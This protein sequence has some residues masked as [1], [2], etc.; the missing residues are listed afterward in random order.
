MKKIAFDL[1]GTLIT[2]SGLNEDFKIPLLG[3]IFKI[4][5]LRKGVKDLFEYLKAK[6]YQICIYTSSYR[7]AFYIKF[8]FMLYLIKLDSIINQYIHEKYVKV[9]SSKFPPEFGIDILVDDSEGV[10][11]EGNKFGFK[12]ILVKAEDEDWVNYI[13]ERIKV[14]ENN[15]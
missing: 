9:N 3:N 8:I 5:K 4:E 14:L 15:L 10:L 1:D 11:M 2:Q 7:S 12:V 13:K 6:K